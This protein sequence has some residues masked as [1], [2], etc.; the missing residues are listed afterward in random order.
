EYLKF[1]EGLHTYV[2]RNNFE[3]EDFVGT[4]LIDMYT[5]CGRI[6]RA[7]RVFKSIKEPCLA[8]WNSM[9]SGYSLYG[10]EHK[11]LVCFSE[12]QEKGLRPDRI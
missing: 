7:E 1:G 2:L 6:D 4:A 5:K 10:L 9:I 12:M 11:A 3:G 8:T